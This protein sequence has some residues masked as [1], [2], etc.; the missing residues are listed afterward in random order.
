MM[1]RTIPLALA[2]LLALGTAPALAQ[3]AES[4]V[5]QRAE[6]P[7]VGLAME[8]PADWRVSNPEGLR[9]S[10]ITTAD[11]E[12]VMET[13]AFMANAGGG[14][15]CSVDA[16]IGLKAPLE[17][18]AY[19]YAAY[20]QRSESES[21]AMVLAET[22]LPAGPAYRIE[23][24]DQ[25]TGRIRA[26]YLFDG[27]A[28]EDGTFNRFLMV[29]AAREVTEPFW[30]PI[31]ESA[32]VFEPVPAEDEMAESEMADDEVADDAPEATGESTEDDAE[33]E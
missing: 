7:E 12:P 25:A 14:T 1:R 8:F 29:C 26:M 10:A 24:F 30:E 11:D 13:T 3:D 32:E 17:S 27:P 33:E 5:T 18:H 20:L 19:Q 4:T 28:G 2:A 6:A 31:A 21:V 15:W 23:L 22:E 16:Y 9:V